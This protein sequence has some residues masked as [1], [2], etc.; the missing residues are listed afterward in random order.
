MA[1]GTRR[2]KT[3]KPSFPEIEQCW[4]TNTIHRKHLATEMPAVRL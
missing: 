4:N 3:M 2:V 1:L